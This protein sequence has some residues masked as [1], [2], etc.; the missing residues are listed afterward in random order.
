MRFKALASELKGSN[1]HQKALEID[2]P[3]QG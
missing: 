1:L 2:T 3:L